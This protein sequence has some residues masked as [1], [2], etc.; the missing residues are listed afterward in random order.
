MCYKRNYNKIQKCKLESNFKN[1][2]FRIIFWN[3]RV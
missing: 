2:Y 1:F 3:S